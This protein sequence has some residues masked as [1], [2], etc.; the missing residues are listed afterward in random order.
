MGR[1]SFR[2][3]NAARWVV[4]SLGVWA[5]VACRLDTA[6]GNATVRCTKTSQCPRGELCQLSNGTCTARVDDVFP[7]VESA[8]ASWAAG[9]DNPIAQPTALTYGSTLSVSFSVNKPLVGI[10]EL[11]NSVGLLCEA[12]GGTSL[13]FKYFG[14]VPSSVPAS[15]DERV[16]FTARLE[17]AVRHVVDAQLPVDVVLDTAAPPAPDTA[18][19]G[20]VV[21]ERIPWGAEKSQGLP[22]F[23]V[24]GLAGAA[25]E[26]IRL[27]ARSGAIDR[28]SGPVAEDGSFALALA[29]VD[30]PELFI[31][32]VDKAGNRSAE[33]RVNDVGWVATLGQKVAGSTF[34]NPHRLVMARAQSQALLRADGDERGAADGLSR[35]DGVSATAHGAGT[36]QKRVF[37]VEF[38]V[39]G[40][41]AVVDD[42]ARGRLVTYGG[43]DSFVIYVESDVTREWT[44]ADFLEMSVSDPEGDQSPAGR[45]HATMA[46]DSRSRRSI[47]TGGLLFG[48]STAETWA[49]NGASWRRLAD[50]PSARWG[51]AVWYDARADRLFVHSGATGIAPTDSRLFTFVNNSW[52]EFDAGSSPT[53]RV[54]AGVAYDMNAGR[55]LLF[56]GQKSDATL[57]NATW[58]FDGAQWRAL[59]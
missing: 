17:D 45:S 19:D 5:L 37:K 7:A 25:P 15:I 10:P 18:G 58:S 54:G 35:V 52:S 50:A 59:P 13:S 46:Y 44:G 6:R 30:D 31:R 16:D 51:S 29:P 43:A 36:W 47:L 4:M 22:A 23:E 40:R 39:M 24:R 11:R 12:T 42:M 26:A 14:S 34:E 9:P 1:G 48:Q 32:T 20:V 49:W 21:Y 38:P 41:L 57:S 56:G 28:G 8:S 2:A 27:T 3:V 55:A 53:P 33:V